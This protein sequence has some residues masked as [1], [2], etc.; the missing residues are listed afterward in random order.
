MRRSSFKLVPAGL[1]ALFILFHISPAARAA[2]LHNEHHWSVREWAVENGLPSN[3]VCGI[4]QTPD[5]F[6]WIATREGLSRFD[7]VHFDHRPLTTFAALPNP[8]LRISQAGRD[9]GLWLGVDDGALVHYRANGDAR[10]FRNGLPNH[11]PDSVV[12]DR[13]GRLWIG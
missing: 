10:V 4:A 11:Q 6:L 2:D 5:G 13:S 1:L 9:G 7:G 3:W 12:E 8:Q